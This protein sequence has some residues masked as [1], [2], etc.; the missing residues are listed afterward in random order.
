MTEQA[1]PPLALDFLVSIIAGAL[2]GAV[3]AKLLGRP[4]LAGAVGGGVTFGLVTVAQRLG[5][6]V[7]RGA[8]AAHSPEQEQLAP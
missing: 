7:E 4:A 6:A 5:S 8:L 1:R 3:S 2:A